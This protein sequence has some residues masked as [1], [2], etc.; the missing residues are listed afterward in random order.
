MSW[1]EV[2]EYP[3][4]AVSTCGKVRGRYGK[5]LRGETNRDG[6]R[7]VMMYKKGLPRKNMLIHRLVAFAFVENPRPDI[8]DCVD[9]ID[10]DCTNNDHTNLRWVNRTLSQLNR[11]TAKGWYYNKNKRNPYKVTFR[12]KHFGVFATAE[13]AHAKYKQVQAETFAYLYNKLVDH[14]QVDYAHDP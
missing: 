4:Y 2:D 14:T 1:R 10:G 6:R 12:R 13:E 5:I 8:F 7:C 3:G 9:H 11:T